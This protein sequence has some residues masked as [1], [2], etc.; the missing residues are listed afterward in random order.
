MDGGVWWKAAARA[1]LGQP[2]HEHTKAFLSKVLYQLYP[3]TTKGITI[4]TRHQVTTDLAPSLAGP[5][6]QAIVANGFL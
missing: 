1:S 4:M 3:I 5:Y 2:Q 6:F